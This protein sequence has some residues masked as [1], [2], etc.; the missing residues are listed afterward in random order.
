MFFAFFPTIRTLFKKSV[1]LLT[2]S[3][4]TAL[5]PVGQ[6]QALASCSFSGS[7]A[8]TRC[9]AD[10]IGGRAYAG[11]SS[12]TI[13]DESTTRVELGV[14]TSWET[15]ATQTL[16]ITGNTTIDNP[17]DSA[18]YFDTFAPNH[19]LDVYIGEDVSITSSGGYGTISLVQNGSGD[20]SVVNDGAVTAGPDGS[21]ILANPGILVK[22]RGGKMS[23]VN[24]GYVTSATGSGIEAFGD[25]FGSSGAAVSIVNNGVIDASETGIE[26]KSYVGLSTITNTG[27]V[28]SAW[29][30]GLLA[31]SEWGDVSIYNS[32]TVKTGYN[33]AIVA[34]SA[35]GNITIINN[36]WAGND[37]GSPG[38]AA[39]AG[40][41]GDISITNTGTLLAPWEVAISAVSDLGDISIVNS[42][43]ITGWGGIEARTAG[44]RIDVENSGTIEAV[45]DVGVSLW[46]GGR[47]TNTGTISGALGGVFLA[48]SGNTITTSGTISG[49]EASILFVYDGGGNTLNILPNAV[50]EGVVDYNDSTGNTTTFGAGSYRIPVADYLAAEN[51]IIL[52][53]PSQVVVLS[54]ADTTGTINVVTAT[55]VAN[56]ASQYTNSVSDVIGSILSL[57]LQRPDEVGGNIPG[58]E[59]LAYGEVKQASPAQQAIARIGEGVALDRVGNLFWTRA[60]GG[61]RHQPD[62]SDSFESAIY[63]YGLMAGVDRRSGDMRIGA[64]AGGG[65]VNADLSNTSDSI[66]GQ[67]GF[68]GIYGTVPVNGFVFSTSLTV[69]AIESD[70]RRAVNGGEWAEGNFWGWYVSPEVSVSRRYDVASGWS[71]MPSARLRYV[72]AFYEGYTESGSSQNISYDARDTHALEGR[73]QMDLTRRAMLESGRAA[74]FTLT[75][76]VVDTQHLGDNGYAASLD[77]T[78]FTLTDT[79]ARNVAGLRL[80]ASFDVQIKE[81]ISLYGG[82]EGTIYTDESV[83]YTGRLGLKA[84]F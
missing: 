52:D 17:D 45:E 41:S 20:I 1:F 3:T 12:L 48:G 4:T 13:T 73:L 9:D 77:G 75:G 69:G 63:H 43:N 24:N 67:T 10:V 74:A 7:F 51:S 35:A 72:G 22:T 8:S 64:F 76:A 56:I 80:G 55:P 61:G 50:F 19:T 2:L 37:D 82:I 47:L 34:S 25:D 18:V 49:G 58:L 32:G 46:S 71:L 84:A 39:R 62:T 31:D 29:G 23:V 53:N 14:V 27:T 36:G 81:A 15:P 44:G 60:F 30:T 78:E 66:D 83:A 79:T 70:A 68:A 28:T 65:A 54:D 11:T 42:G 59:P 57:D 16:T 40:A 33:T 6:G 38:I 26:A 5:V 21:G